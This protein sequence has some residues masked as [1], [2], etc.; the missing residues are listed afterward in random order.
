VLQHGNN[1]TIIRFTHLIVREWTVNVFKN[2]LMLLVVT[3]LAACLV[4]GCGTVS[5][6]AKTNMAPGFIGHI[7]RVAVWSDLDNIARLSTKRFGMADSFANV[8]SAT[9]KNDLASAGATAEVRRLPA[10][11]KPQDLVKSEQEFSPQYRLLITVPKYRVVKS[12]TSV[13]VLDLNLEINLFTVQDRRRVW[14][15]EF[16]LRRGVIP[17]PMS[18][19]ETDAQQLAHDL[20]KLLRKDGLVN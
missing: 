8:F 12:N 1:G 17:T 3:V 20:V 6:P 14:H 10:L 7:S 5:D 9:L 19:N 16:V 4:A 11:S 13:D 15:S 2:R 18:W